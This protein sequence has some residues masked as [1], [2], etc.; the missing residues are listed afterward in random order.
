[1]QAMC[2][3]VRAMPIVEV[4]QM[5]IV[6]FIHYKGKKWSLGTGYIQLMKEGMAF[7]DIGCALHEQDHEN[8]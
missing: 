7:W 5:A 1:M 2:L 8:I 3:R 4:R 6:L